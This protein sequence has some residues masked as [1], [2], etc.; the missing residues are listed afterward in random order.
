MDE[1]AVDWLSFADVAISTEKGR[2]LF[3]N[4]ELDCYFFKI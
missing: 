3:V 4:L 1:G 2:F